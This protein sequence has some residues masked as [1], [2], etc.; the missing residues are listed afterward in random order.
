MTTHRTPSTHQAPSP[1]DDRAPTYHRLATKLALLG[2]LA[3]PSLAEAQEGRE[4]STRDVI[5]TIPDYEG[6]DGIVD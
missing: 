1:H 3:F 4:Q 2:T 5:L 6:A